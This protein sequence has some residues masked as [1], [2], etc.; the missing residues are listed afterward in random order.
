VDDP[1]PNARPE[2]ERPSEPGWPRRLAAEVFGTF[3]LVFAAAGG[4]VMAHVSGGEVSTAARAIA[5]ALMVAALIY[6]IGDTSGAHFNPAVTL[7][8][9]LKRLVP[10]WWVPAY[11]LAQVVGAILAASVLR[12]L[13]GDAI[14]TGVSRPKLVGA[15]GALGLEVILTVFLV[16]VIVA[17]D[18]ANVWI[19][20]T[21]PILGGIVA[22]GLTTFLHGRVDHDAKSREAA[23]GSGKP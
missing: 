3:G 18:L 15:S 21:G 22:V 5:P 16:S 2:F 17:G 23:R 6:S 12:I 9:G 19:Y 10:A 20:V 13:F 8:F 1:Q 11:W 7:S 14:Q 4:D